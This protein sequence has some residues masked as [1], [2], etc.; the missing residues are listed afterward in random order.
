[1]VGVPEGSGPFIESLCFP[2]LIFCLSMYYSIHG[3]ELSYS[4]HCSHCETLRFIAV[5]T[6]VRHLSHP[7]QDEWNLCPSM[8]L[9]KIKFHIL[10]FMPRSSNWCLSFKC[11]RETPISISPYPT[12]HMP[13]P[14]HSAWVHRSKSIW[15][16][17]QITKLLLMHFLLPPGGIYVCCCW[18][19]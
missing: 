14:S 9:F 2:I 18:N 8:L 1:M 11:I 12:C 16:G 3:T 13:W 5:N 19:L 17:I 7:E 15:W 10:P 6:R 4:R